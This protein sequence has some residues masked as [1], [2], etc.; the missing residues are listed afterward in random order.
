MV[1]QSILLT[2]FIEDQSCRESSVTLLRQFRDEL[3]TF[4]LAGHE[5]SAAMMTWTI[6]ELMAE[7]KLM[8]QVATEASHVFD[9]KIDWANAPSSSLPDKETLNKLVLSEA[10]LKVSF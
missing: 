2:T 7:T 4:M 5:T 8:G 6:Y 3:K 1:T 9:D 10:S